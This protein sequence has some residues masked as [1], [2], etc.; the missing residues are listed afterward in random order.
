VGLYVVAMA[1]MSFIA[2]TLVKDR[3]GTT[4]HAD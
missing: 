3:P 2:V 1:V 4:L